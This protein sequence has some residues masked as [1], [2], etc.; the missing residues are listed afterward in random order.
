MKLSKDEELLIEKLR[1]TEEIK[2]EEKPKKPK[3][4][5]SKMI[6]T[7]I[8]L[9]NLIF[10]ISILV[11]FLQTGSEPSTLIT[12]F[13]AFTTVELWSLAGIKKK[14]YLTQSEPTEEVI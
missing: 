3:P 5:F 8:I 6:V 10:T 13:F 7:L 14:E 11:V 2:P 4:K 12:A 9:M 1:A